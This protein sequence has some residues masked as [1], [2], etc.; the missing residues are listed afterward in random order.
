MN[1]GK[2]VRIWLEKCGSLYYKNKGVKKVVIKKDGTRKIIALLAIIVLL[3]SS[4]IALAQEVVGDESD[5]LK[6]EEQQD[7]GGYKDTVE[8]IDEEEAQEEEQ[9][10]DELDE[11][12][13]D[14]DDKGEGYY[15]LF[16]FS[17]LSVQS[18]PNYDLEIYRDKDSKLYWAKFD[19]IS[20]YYKYP[21]GKATF[22]F[23][24]NS[25]QISGEDPYTISD[26]EGIPI[27]IF[28]KTG[29]VNNSDIHDE[30]Y[31]DTIIEEGESVV[32][33]G[34][35]I[36]LV[37][38][39]N[40]VWTFEVEPLKESSGQ[41]GA[42]SHFQF[43]YT[44]EPDEPSAN[45][46]TIIKT[47]NSEEG[48]AHEKV[49]FKLYKSKRS[50]P[51]WEKIAEGWTNNEG[52]I[53]FGELEP[54]KYKIVEEVP[55][56]YTSSL[57]YSPFPE[58][59]I[60]LEAGEE[61][62]I[63]VIN[64]IPTITVVKT[65]ENGD[66]HQ[67]VPFQLF[68]NCFG[69][70]IPVG[71][72]V[73]TDAEGVAEFGVHF[74][75]WRYK[76]KEIVPE[77]YYND[78]E[79]DE[80]VFW[81]NYKGEEIQVVNYKD[82]PVS[83]TANIIVSKSMADKSSAKGIKFTLYK[84]VD[85]VWESIVEPIET[86]DDGV[87]EFTKLEAGTYK[88][89]EEELSDY[90]ADYG[91]EEGIIV[92][93]GEDITVRVVNI[94][95]PDEPTGSIKVVKTLDEL[96]GEPHENVRFKLYR[97]P[98]EPTYTLALAD[99]EEWSKISITDESGE[100]EFEGLDCEYYYILEEMDMDDYEVKYYLDPDFEGS[101]ECPDI[102]VDCEN[103][104]TVYVVNTKKGGDDPNGDDPGGDDDKPSGG[105]GR[106]R[107]TPE[108]IKVP[109]EPEVFTPPV[110]EPV[111]VEEPLVTAPV[112]PDLPHTGGNPAAFVFLG[113]ALAGLGLY[114]RKRR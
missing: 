79:N 17:D 109:E 85:E 112:L 52:I 7:P 65:K 39:S 37:S 105:G 23:D 14:E 21:Q 25:N 43:R 96:G 87:A 93:D 66:P 27:G 1:E 95:V 51:Y 8:G 110:E 67:G 101:D 3:A 28:V 108:T 62:E 20:G 31:L 114:V 103:E 92:L 90:Y 84:L 49:R 82:D 45:S 53:K 81:L 12:E 111:V 74:I 59:V 5:P 22:I 6:Q 64:Y 10:E 113:A 94:P 11:D 88:V 32:L 60:N 44:G 46:I 58:E 16:M 77:G 72:P 19:N 13:L 80:Y 69:D 2:M 91:E 76:V 71:D 68:K 78:W 26:W 106:R 55:F 38:Y 99:Y 70:W 34:F 36:S 47:I 30:D 35:K 40:G 97:Y 107:P 41:G 50:F 48:K 18:G 4:S 100:A 83:E 61:K 63:K 9:E 75:G 56:G 24:I 86:D 89:E 29:N 104:T 42:L 57:G 102:F 98:L 73:E 15:G 33:Q 54:G